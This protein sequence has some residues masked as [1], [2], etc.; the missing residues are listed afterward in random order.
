MSKSVCNTCKDQGFIEKKVWAT[1]PQVPG[2]HPAIQAAT[3][4]SR[5][6]TRYRCPDCAPKPG[7]APNM[8]YDTLEEKRMDR[9]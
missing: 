5:T 1:P 2:V 7:P 9:E 4:A 3:P 6:V 8:G